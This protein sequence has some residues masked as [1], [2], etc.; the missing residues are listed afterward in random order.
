MFHVPEPWNGNLDT[1]KIL[2]V[3]SNPSIDLNEKKF[4]KFES[5]EWTEDKKNDV[6]DF[7]SNRLESYKNR[8]WTGILKYAGYILKKTDSLRALDKKKDEDKIRE[9][10]SCIALT[11]IVHCKSKGET[12]VK[13]AA[14]TCFD[15]HT[16]SVIKHFLETR[17]ESEKK[18]SETK[19]TVV[20]VGGKARDLIYAVANKK[21][22]SIK[23]EPISS[24]CKSEFGKRGKD[25]HFLFVPHPNARQWKSQKSGELYKKLP[26]D[27]RKEIIDEQLQQYV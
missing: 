11:E 1:A 20:F 21:A 26:N 15:T 24:F 27:I 19:K 23:D 12:G 7:F 25:A 18:Q 3:S 5:E 10:A 13:K 4:P 9:I 22:F 6:V 17:S 14:K 8:Y 2:F 16:K